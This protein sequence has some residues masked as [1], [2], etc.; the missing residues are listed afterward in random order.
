MPDHVFCLWLSDFAK[1]MF[2]WSLE[3][4]RKMKKGKSLSLSLWPSLARGPAK[5]RLAH[6]P[7]WRGPAAAFLSPLFPLSPLGPVDFPAR[8]SSARPSRL[9]CPATDSPTPTVRCARGQLPSRRR[10]LVGPTYK[11]HP[12]NRPCSSSLSSQ[13][14]FLSL[15][16]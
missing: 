1:S 16:R 9:P 11:P 15:P 3:L 10:H 6:G 4:N 7:P 13:H 2:G 14:M 12:K 5:P 8:P